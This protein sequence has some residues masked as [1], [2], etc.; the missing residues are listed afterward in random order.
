MYNLA[1]WKLPPSIAWIRCRIPYQQPNRGDHDLDDGADDD[2]P[3]ADDH[4]DD[5]DYD[6]EALF[7][8]NTI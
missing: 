8:E 2:D 5:Y 7:F 6:D 3:A 4:G 1:E